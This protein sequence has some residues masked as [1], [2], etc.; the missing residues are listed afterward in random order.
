MDSTPKW[1]PFLYGSILNLMGTL[2]LG[3]LWGYVPTDGG[4]FTAPS[5]VIISLGICL[6]S[7]G[8]A[9][10]LPSKSPSLV[11]SALLVI[12]LIALALVCNWTAFAP[13]VEY[14]SSATL[15]MIEI[16]GQDQIGGRIVFGLVAVIIDLV[17]LAIF[18][19]L[20]KQSH[21]KK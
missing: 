12:T 1:I 5:W 6:L 9:F 18:V 20:F 17:I 14:Q 13:G 16:A 8:A 2:I 3:A 4:R 7:A 21:S 15:G 11:K 19:N 10:W